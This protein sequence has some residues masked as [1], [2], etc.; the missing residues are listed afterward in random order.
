MRKLLI[1]LLLIVPFAN[2]SQVDSCDEDNVALIRSKIEKSQSSIFY[3]PFEL[4]KKFESICEIKIVEMMDGM[5]YRLYKNI[6]SNSYFIGLYN[7]LDGSNQ[8][9]GPFVE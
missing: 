8:M 7:G 6:E 9:H 1:L 2:A 5:S 3:N 4:D